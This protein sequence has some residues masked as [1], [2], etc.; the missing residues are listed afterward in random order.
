MAIRQS[1]SHYRDAKNMPVKNMAAE[2]IDPLARKPVLSVNFETGERTGSLDDFY[3]TKEDVKDMARPRSD[4]TK[5]QFI[6][7]LNSSKNNAEAARKLGIVTSTFYK[8]RRMWGL[9]EPEK[10]TESQDSEKEVDEV[11]DNA[12]V[13]LCPADARAVPTDE[14]CPGE[15]YGACD[16]PPDVERITA[17]DA[18][19]VLDELRAEYYSVLEIIDQVDK[20][21]PAVMLTLEGQQYETYE[22]IEH[23]EDKLRGI[24]VEV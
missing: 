5:E 19:D 18:F 15:R 12:E 22:K 9:S 3:K 20:I 23:L 17:L 2:S 24:T 13:G 11:K 6:D 4:I 1:G 10:P 8:Y 14:E 7:A 16:A 21:H